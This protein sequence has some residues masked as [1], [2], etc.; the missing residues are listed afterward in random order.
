MSSGCGVEEGV[1]RWSAFSSWPGSVQFLLPV[2]GNCDQVCGWCW[3]T[4]WHMRCP[5]R[6]PAQLPSAS[7]LR[8]AQP[9]LSASPTITSADRVFT[10]SLDI[11][12]AL[13]QTLAH[14]W[15]N[16][17]VVVA[18]AFQSRPTCPCCLSPILST[19]DVLQVCQRANTKWNAEFI[20]FHSQFRISREILLGTFPFTHHPFPNYEAPLKKR[21]HP[22]F[23]LCS[24][25]WVPHFL[26]LLFSSLTLHDSLGV[27]LERVLP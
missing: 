10:S 18:E 24:S 14:V 1:T 9:L 21:Q 16:S 17:G 26:L 20:F 12:L 8:K 19:G 23:L 27:V 13:C 15:E 4:G 5:L 11:F 2:L 6:H 22:L 7:N 3:L 25:N